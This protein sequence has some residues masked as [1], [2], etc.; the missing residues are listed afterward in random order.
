MEKVISYVSSDREIYWCGYGN[1]DHGQGW[2]GD[3]DQAT[4]YGDDAADLMLG[5]VREWTGLLAEARVIGP[6]R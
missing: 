5:T 4:R 6:A 1:G 2:T 3:P